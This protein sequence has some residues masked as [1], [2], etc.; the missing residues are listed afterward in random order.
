MKSCDVS[1]AVVGMG[2]EGIHWNEGVRGSRV[3]A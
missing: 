1:P 3:A 2:V